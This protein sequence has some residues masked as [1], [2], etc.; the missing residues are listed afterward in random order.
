MI[1]SV[2][3]VFLRRWWWLVLLGVG[4]SLTA[5]SY[6]LSRQPLLYSATATIE[7][8]RMFQ[9]KNPA[10]DQ[11]SVTD[12]LAK[13]Y[14]QIAQR[15][16]LLTAT[17]KEL[18]LSMTPADLRAR[19]LVSAAS[20]T[21]MVDVLVV[22][23][24]PQRAAAIANEIA[25]QV[26]L[27][28]PATSTQ[29]D[30]EQAFILAQLKDLKAKITD[31]QDTITSLNNQIAAMTSAADIQDAQQRLAALQA[32]VD[33]WQ[34]SY[35]QLLAAAQ[36]S[37][38]NT[39]SVASQAVVPT[40]PMATS[41]R[42]YYMLA[43]AVG[44]AIS[45]VLALVLDF[46]NPT[47]RGLRDLDPL[48]PDLPVLA[49]P[50]YRVPRGLIPAVVAAPASDEAAAYRSLRNSLQAAGITRPGLSLAIIS[51]R[52]GEGKTT[53]AI[54]LAVALASPGRSIALVDANVRNPELA[55][56]FRSRPAPGFSDL[57]RGAVPLELVS[58][59]VPHPNLRLIAAGA[60]P[61]DY[62]DLLSVPS[63][64][65]TV[66]RLSTRADIVIFDMPAVL[67]DRDALL[68]ARHVDAVLMVVETGRVRRDEFSQTMSLLQ[69][70]NATVVAV[71][72]N[73]VRR[74]PLQLDRLPWS[75]EARRRGRAARRRA[76]TAETAP[77]LETASGT[78]G[79]QP[80]SRP[81]IGGGGE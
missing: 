14:A 5:T 68:L 51:S 79:P 58:Q 1:D 67:E 59:H 13:A 43:I 9:D 18:R 36:P 63:L 72:L 49:I 77:S 12:Q 7:V 28:S 70:S 44:A 22:D 41:K 57:L 17:A 62:T 25:R 76:L 47:V 27:Q 46:F 4:I 31:G 80:R 33:S 23:T 78:S 16:A 3:I 21:G 29:G 2:Y 30:A 56:R 71:A 40:S 81:V 60:I 73:K 26:V 24:D 32:Q 75:R 11:L 65:E 8:G 20:A 54:N 34:Q 42:L 35:A 66:R 69:Q 48:D 61:A 15:D 39:V 38:T 10:P 37:D 52:A 55:E 50:R 53:T 74:F 64:G 6:A 45:T 19:L